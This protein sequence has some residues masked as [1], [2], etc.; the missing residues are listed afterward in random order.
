MDHKVIIPEQKRKLRPPFAWIDKRVLFN[1]FLTELSLY[2]MLL[3]FFLVLVADRDGLS[4]YSY[5]KICQILKFDVDAYIES[6]NGLIQKKLIAFKDSLFQVLDLPDS[7]KVKQQSSTRHMP[8]Q[9]KVTQ[10]KAAQ[11][12]TVEFQSMKALFAHLKDQCVQPK[13]KQW[14]ER[15]RP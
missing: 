7:I 2:E 8:I 5:D 3:Y 11:S 4:F 10:I 14:P 1:G 13:P 9:K 12:K 15:E 6:R